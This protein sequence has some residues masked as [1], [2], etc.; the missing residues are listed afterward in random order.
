MPPTGDLQV[1]DIPS[2]II[3]LRRQLPDQILRII[4]RIN[5]PIPIPILLLIL[6]PA[7]EKEFQP[8]IITPPPHLHMHDP[9]DMLI[10]SRIVLVL[11]P[12]PETTGKKPR[13]RKFLRMV[14]HD[15]H[16]TE[17]AKRESG[18]HL[19]PKLRRPKPPADSRYQ[20]IKYKPRIRIRLRP[21]SLVVGQTRSSIF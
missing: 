21:P 6:R 10:V 19:F 12:P 4:D 1:A 20:L 15:I 8:G 13:L 3:P 17:C 11:R 14:P 7:L 2:L 16:R 9:V 18:K 5:H